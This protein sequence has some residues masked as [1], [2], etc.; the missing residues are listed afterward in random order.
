MTDKKRISATSI[1]FESMPY[2][3]DP[4]TGLIDYDKLAEHARLFRPKMII[5]GYSAYSRLLDYARFK[6]VS[7]SNIELCQVIQPQTWADDILCSR[8]LK[9]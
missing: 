4:N 9:D 3:L 5:A 6:Q 2:R 1:Y 7:P 8:F